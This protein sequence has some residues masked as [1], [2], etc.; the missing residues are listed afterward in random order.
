MCC[1]RIFFFFYGLGLS[2]PQQPC[3][4]GHHTQPNSGLKEIY[5][6]I[7][8]RLPHW[9]VT[10][11]KSTGLNTPSKST[12][13]LPSL[14]CV[15]ARVMLINVYVRKKKYT[16]VCMNFKA[17]VCVCVLVFTRD[18]AHSRPNTKLPYWHELH[19]HADCQDTNSFFLRI[20]HSPIVTRT[21]HPP[22]HTT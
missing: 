19:N 16:G 10:T 4:N 11:A 7:T 20:P 17:R 5:R 9:R 22:Q 15:A 8:R 14:W 18:C 2:Q 21:Q 12:T 1:A 3:D 13:W 6:A